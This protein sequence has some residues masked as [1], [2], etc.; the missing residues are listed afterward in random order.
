VIWRRG[1]A[2]QTL[3]KRFARLHPDAFFVEIGANDG[4]QHDHLRP[5]IL[6]GRWRGLMVEPVPYVFERLRQNYAGVDGVTLVNSA[7]SAGRDGELDF[8]YLRDASPGERAGLP[9]WYDGIGSFSRDA[10][11]GHERHMPDISERIVEARVPAYTFD[12]LLER[13]GAPSPDLVVI[14]TEGY[15][16]EIIAAI[17]F[18]RHRPT[19]LVYEHYHFDPETREATR[20]AMKRAGYRTIE[21]GFD[22][23]CVQGMRVGRVKPIVGGVARYEEAA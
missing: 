9:D 17:D 13:H 12:S 1:T 3:L 19:L 14:D 2:L 5:F 16:A 10:I 4:L 11:L 6:S 20:A 22:T 7:V 15:D 23:I 21:E 18:D 8:Y